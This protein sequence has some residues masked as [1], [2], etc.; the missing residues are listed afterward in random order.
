[1]VYTQIAHV[2]NIV[3]YS[4]AVKQACIFTGGNISNVVNSLHTGCHLVAQIYAF[5][6]VE[7][8]MFATVIQAKN[9]VE[10]KEEAIEFVLMSLA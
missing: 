4:S 7:L 6:Y 8:N 10:S 9:L 1:M 2:Y 3:P 5:L